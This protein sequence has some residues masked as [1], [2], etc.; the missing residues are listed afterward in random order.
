MVFVVRT[1]KKR[2]EEELD[3]VLPIR[4]FRSPS[5]RKAT[6]TGGRGKEC[7]AALIT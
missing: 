5:E 7:G 4:G 2:K 1:E 6:R 3:A